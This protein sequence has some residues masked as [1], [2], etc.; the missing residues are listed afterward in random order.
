MRHTATDYYTGVQEDLKTFPFKVAKAPD[1]GVLVNLMYEKVCA[2]K[3]LCRACA[4]GRG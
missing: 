1:G 4:P 2:S 3:V